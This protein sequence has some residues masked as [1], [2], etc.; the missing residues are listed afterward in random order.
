MSVPYW[1]PDLSSSISASFTYD[2][3]SHGWGNQELQDY[4]N[5]PVNSFIGP[6][7]KSIV[8]RAIAEMDS[9]GRP[10][11][12]SARLVSK[13]CLGQERGY[14]EA[15]IKTPFASES[16]IALHHDARIADRL[17]ERGHLV[18]LLAATKSTLHLARRWG[19]GHL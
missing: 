12:T 11:Y 14:V 7:G 17:L 3:G 8:I 9:T 15:C 13:A 19:G 2:L 4:T 1:E 6:D 5:S 10:R 18:C 16:A